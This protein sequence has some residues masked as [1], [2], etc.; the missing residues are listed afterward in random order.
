MQ[1]LR[2][3]Q[4][5]W[6]PAV[7]GMCKFKITFAVS[8]TTVAGYILGKGMLD[9]GIVLPTLALWLVASG[10]AALN[11]WQEWPYDKEMGRTS[12]RPIPVGL[13]SPNLVLFTASF[14]IGVGC[15]GMFLAAGTT[16]TLL[17][18]LAVFWYNGFYTP[19]KRKSPYTVIPGGLIGAL[20]PM[21]GYVVA[22]G[23]MT[24][25]EIL[26]FCFFIFIWQ[27]PHFWLLSLH[28]GEQY[29]KA[30]FPCVTRMFD[31][32]QMH[33]IVYSWILTCA[34]CSLTLPVLKASYNPYTLAGLLVLSIWISVEERKL[35]FSVEKPPYL[36]A[37]M[38]LNLYALLVMVLIAMDEIL[39]HL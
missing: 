30:G 36:K 35:L 38:E 3:Q 5:A 4:F 22:H 28:Y 19:M 21:I 34:L 14:L 15:I 20:P 12:S 7:L 27:V 23:Q 17:S 25:P 13:M 26:S 18:G 31:R 37:F 32:A 9:F 16:A 39:L 2:R 29:E 1:V 11:H 24:D 33:R 10:S 6:L 8:T